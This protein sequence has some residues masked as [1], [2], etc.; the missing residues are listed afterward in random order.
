MLA[1]FK[2]PFDSLV[3]WKAN[4]IPWVNWSPDGNVVVT[5]TCHGSEMSP[6]MKFLKVRSLAWKK[7]N[8]GCSMTLVSSN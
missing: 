3:Y 1:I 7:M 2:E 5:F 4:V 8:K 6:R